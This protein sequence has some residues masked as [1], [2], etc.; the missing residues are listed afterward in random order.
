MRTI[1]H[2]IDDVSSIL[3]QRHTN[4][5]LKLSCGGYPVDWNDRVV[6]TWRQLSQVGEDGVVKDF[7]RWS[8]GDYIQKA[9]TDEILKSINDDWINNHDN[10]LNQWRKNNGIHQKKSN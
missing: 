2:H 1:H 8:C 7:I 6:C 3:I 9:C 10:K 4:G 5:D